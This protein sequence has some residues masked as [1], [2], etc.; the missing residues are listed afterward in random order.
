MLIKN[1]ICPEINS[2]FVGNNTCCNLVRFCAVP[3]YHDLFI[4]TILQGSLLNAPA[5]KFL[6][7]RKTKQLQL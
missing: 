3:H 4:A 5:V 2:V 1:V 7:N 6:N